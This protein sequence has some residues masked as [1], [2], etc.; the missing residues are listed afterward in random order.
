[1]RVS[2]YSMCFTQINYGSV[3]PPSDSA[4][5]ANSRGVSLGRALSAPREILLVVVLCWVPAL[6]ALD[7]C[8][9]GLLMQLADLVA[10][11]IRRHALLVGVTIDAS[12]VLRAVVVALVVGSGG[13]DDVPKHS[14]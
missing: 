2:K 9:D 5:A 13:V 6:G 11:S 3:C 14:Q 12:A 4:I 7:L 1:M 10:R 8:D